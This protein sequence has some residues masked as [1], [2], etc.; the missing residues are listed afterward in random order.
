[1]QA[2]LA[3]G[4][5]VDTKNKSGHTPLM[6]AKKEGKKEI[7]RMLKE[8]GQRNEGMSIYCGSSELLETFECC[9]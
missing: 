5:D 9:Y 6:L 3:K 2:L 8:A 4:A 1:V 7:I